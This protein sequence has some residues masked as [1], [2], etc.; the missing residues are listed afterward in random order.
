MKIIILEGIATS[1]KT[2]IK[3]K[4]AKIFQEKGFDF[5]IVEE[6][7][8]LM[9][10][11]DNFD[12][13]ISINLMKK[14][15]GDALNSGKQIIVF[16]RLF[17]THIFRTNSAIS[18]FKEIEDML[19]V[20]SLLVFLKIAEEKIPERIANARKHRDQAWNEYVSKK[21][22]EEEINGYYI[23]QQKML[24]DVLKK[25]SL[26]FRIYDTSE[27]NFDKISQ[28]IVLSFK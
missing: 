8:T 2:T 7:E 5:S 20:N 25:T 12:R 13:Q 10:I 6:D 21:G 11:I 28:D 14:V 24:L 1:G 9:P 19:K 3:N 26:K 15:I 17:F 4:L 27:M 23:N 16:D 18:D 22:S